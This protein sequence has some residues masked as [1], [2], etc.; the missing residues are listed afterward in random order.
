MAAAVLVFQQGLLRAA[1]LDADRAQERAHAA[2][3]KQAALV[4]M[5]DTIEHETTKAL[6][7][8]GGLVLTL[9]GTADGMEAS[10]G[11]TGASARNA[12]EA[13][14]Q[15][16]ASS[17]TVAAAAEQLSSSIHEIGTQVAL[18]TTMVGRAVQAGGESR[19]TM[20]SLNEKVAQIGT[21]A[22]MISDIAGRTNLLALNATIEAAR[23][24]EAG[25]GFAVVASEVK[26]LATQTARSTEEIAHQIAEVRAAAGSS[27]AAVL[28]IEQTI[29][30][31]QDIAASIAAAVEQQGAATAEIARN[32]TLTS[33]IA[34]ALSG[35]M[36][37]VSA[38]ARATAAQAMDVHRNASGLTGA[39]SDLRQ[40]LMRVVRTSTADV[41]RRRGRRRTCLAEATIRGEGGTAIGMVRDISETGC[42]VETMLV[43]RP[44]AR[45][46]VALDRFGL[47]VQG[48][49]AACADG[50]VHVMF[51]GGGVTA[52][53]ADRVSLE[54]VADL[55]GQTRSDHVAFVQKVLDAVAGRT[56]L[57]PAA[58][59][60]HRECRLGRWY[61]SV[62]DP[63]TLALPSYCALDA[64]HRAVHETGHAALTA[65]ATG[66]ATA[67]RRHA[68]AMQLQ[69]KQVMS[70]LDA[71][72]REY[73]ATF[74]TATQA[75]A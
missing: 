59:A 54:T 44:G 8:I 33:D 56:T 37:E 49:V 48:T 29:G 40:T 46:D 35:R 13:A 71:F 60:P 66:D 73:P 41:D 42:A 64:P 61:R 12:A 39:M 45:V 52:A 75:A 58:L 27:V 30:E 5:A 69:S 63:A 7:H 6:E 36:G 20:T 21:V 51:D 4:N 23:A 25:R 57:P 65:V 28:R 19:A 10:A 9:T 47:Q 16:M 62:S 11:R 24:G 3:E 70:R 18:S 34:T 72:G 15:A 31:I 14:G 22:D 2:A 67:A 55:V 1:R 43:F 68:Q 17:Q 32:V 50:H 38:E 74:A 26:A 53:D